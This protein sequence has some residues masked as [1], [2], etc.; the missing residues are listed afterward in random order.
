MV[1]KMR[2]NAWQD[3]AREPPAGARLRH[4][5]RHGRLDEHV[6]RAHGP[7]RRGQGL[8]HDRPRGRLLDDERRLAQRLDQLRAPERLD[9]DDV[10]RDPTRSGGSGG[11]A[12]KAETRRKGAA[13]LACLPSQRES[14]E[15]RA[16]LFRAAGAPLE[17]REVDVDEPGAGQVLVRMAA[18]GICGSDLHVVRGEWTRPTPMVLGHEGAGIVEAV[19]PGVESPAPGDPVVLS[20][21]PSCGDVRALPDRPGDGVS[22]RSARR[23]CRDHARRQDGRRGRRRA[24]L[25]HDDDR[26]ARRARARP[27]RHGP[28]P[29]RPTCRSS[30]RRCSAARRS[31]G[32]ARRSTGTGCSPARACSSSAPAAWGSSSSRARGSPARAHRGRR[33]RRGAAR[34]GAR[35]R[36]PRGVSPDD[37]DEVDAF[38]VTF[39]AVGL[40]VTS[41]TAL[42]RRGEEGRPS[43][44][45][46]RRPARGS[47]STRSSSRTA[48]R[49]SPAP[50]T[51]RRARRALPRLLDLVRG[52]E[53]EL[54]S[55]VGPR[56]PLEDANEAVEASLAGSPGRVLVTP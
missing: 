8:L 50:S 33:P 46:C 20:W 40:A 54:A 11:E 10:R 41:E 12:A 1:E 15:T 32:S 28:A 42:A 29:V 38:D 48:R 56:F 3:T 45:A 21:A 27:R 35:A 30:R 26:R 4:G 9:R 44:S 43:S 18:V 47:T 19:G 22:R 14:H 37:F 23:C 53:L 17:L 52:G 24:R 13:K 55:L 51:A 16:A 5:H 31:P 49:R 2:M 39:D 25:S 34:G 6:D 7:H 36:R